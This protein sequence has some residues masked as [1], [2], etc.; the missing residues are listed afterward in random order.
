MLIMNSKDT[1]KRSINKKRHILFTWKLSFIALS[2]RAKLFLPKI[3]P[4]ALYKLIVIMP[5]S[6]ARYIT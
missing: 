6:T 1:I 2:R 3:Y 5:L 4:S